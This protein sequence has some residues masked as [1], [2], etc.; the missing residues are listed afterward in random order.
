MEDKKRIAELESHVA[1]YRKRII[2]FK[3]KIDSDACDCSAVGDDEQYE[4]MICQWEFCANCTKHTTCL[5]HELI[6]ESCS[7]RGFSADPHCAVC[8]SVY[9]EKC[10][11]DCSQCVQMICNNCHDDCFCIEC[12]YLYCEECRVEDKK[13]HAEEKL[14]LY[15][16]LPLNCPGAVLDAV[17]LAMRL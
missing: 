6:C 3:K 17:L 8:L 10:L 4:C 5:C 14:R 2:A 11:K 12:K 16:A 9:C 7:D 1:K 15:M 13:L